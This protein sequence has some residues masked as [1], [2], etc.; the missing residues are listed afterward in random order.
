LRPRLCRRF[1]VF[2]VGFVAAH[3]A[4][5]RR[6]E[7]AMLAGHMAR[8]AAYCGALEAAFG[9]GSAAQDGKTQNGGGKNGV[10]HGGS[11]NFDTVLEPVQRASLH[12]VDTAV[13]RRGAFLQIVDLRLALALRYGDAMNTATHSAILEIQG[14]TFSYPDQP[15]LASGWS[16]SIG[17]GVTLMVGDTGSGKSTLLRILAGVQPADG[18][19]TLSGVRLDESAEAYRR[20]VFFVEP[21]TSVFDRLTARACAASLRE[22]DAAFDERAWHELIEGLSLTPHLDKPM[23]MLSTG[24]KRKVWLAS[25]L[26]SGQPLTVLD[27]PAAALDA[28]SIRCLWRALG[29]RAKVSERTIIIASAERID[30]IPLA[31]TIELPLA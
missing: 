17:T 8:Y 9:F 23:Y 29:E 16:A 14:L 13:P 22:G 10:S 12:S 5:G 1:T 3:G 11:R 4:A 25:A 6:T 2:L 7:N 26:A 21:T 28:G 30:Q 31:G 24:S 27:E 15:P 18:R 19:L 20:N